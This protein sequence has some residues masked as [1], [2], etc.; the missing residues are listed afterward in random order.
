MKAL[1]RELGV[2]EVAPAGGPVS[3]GTDTG[4]VVPA[5]VEPEAQPNAS[6]AINDTADD[7]LCA[8]C[9][10]RVANQKDRFS[11]DGKDEFTFS[12]PE[13]M[14]FQIIAFSRTLGCRESGVPTLEHTWFPGH[15]WSF[16][17]CDEC[18]QHLGWYYTGQHQ[19]A[20]L[21]ITRI[22]RAVCVR[23]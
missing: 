11:Y 22:V 4:V 9:Q 17:Q 8:W 2:V 13:H 3:V 6:T 12:N 5:I 1:L 23:N 20:G 10:N 15:A 7:W 19:F 14:R 18:G 21:I 16:C